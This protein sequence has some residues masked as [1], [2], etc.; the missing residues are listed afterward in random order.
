M[1]DPGLLGVNA[2]ASAAVV[3]GI[4]I[5]GLAASARW[6]DSLSRARR[7]PPSSCTSS[8]PPGGPGPRPYVSPWPGP[9]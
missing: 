8:A 3:F 6:S 1:A 7:S 5:I 4:G 9:P 2:G